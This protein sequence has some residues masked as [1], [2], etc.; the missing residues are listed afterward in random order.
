MV[1][2]GGDFLELA[3]SNARMEFFPVRV[4]TWEYCL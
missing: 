1:R 4:R 2:K 3:V